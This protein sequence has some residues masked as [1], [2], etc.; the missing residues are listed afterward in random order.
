[1]RLLVVFFLSLLI[2]SCQHF[3]R[4]SEE[5]LDKI[6]VVNLDRTPDRYLG[7]K[8]NFE[9]ASLKFTRFRAT[10]GYKINISNKNTG[11]MLDAKSWWSACKQ[12]KP[13]LKNP[14]YEVFCDEDKNNNIIL[15]G[16]STLGEVGCYCSMRRVW[17]DIIDNNYRYSLIFEDDTR[18]NKRD[19]KTFKSQ[20]KALIE[21]APLDWDVIYLH[22]HNRHDKLYPARKLHDKTENDYVWG[23]NRDPAYSLGSTIAY[24]VNRNFAEKMYV[25]SKNMKLPIDMQIADAINKRII[26]G[27]KAKKQLVIVGADSVID[28]M[29]RNQDGKLE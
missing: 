15:S 5:I 6:Y 8:E 9:K 17:K 1:M 25:F 20:I 27:Y 24:I 21:N 29:G 28:N 18:I 19:L 12:N 4:P 16:C 14:A 26:N 22:L 7:A 2:S 3:K 10:D 11:K 23:I 13:N